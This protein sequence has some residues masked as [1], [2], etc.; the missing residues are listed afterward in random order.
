MNSCDWPPLLTAD[1]SDTQLSDDS[2]GTLFGRAATTWDLDNDGRSDTLVGAPARELS[3]AAS[4]GAVFL[5]SG[6]QAGDLTVADAVWSVRGDATDLELGYW[7]TAGWAP[8]DLSP[9]VFIA[10]RGAPSAY[11]FEGP[12][13]GDVS[14]A[15]AVGTLGYDH[16]SVSQVAALG[17][18]DGAGG[19]D[20]AGVSFLDAEEKGEED[21][22]IIR[23]FIAPFI[24]SFQREATATIRGGELL[25]GSNLVLGGQGDIGDDGLGDLVVGAP[26]YDPDGDLNAGAVFLFEDIGT[27][28]M[29]MEDADW[30]LTGEQPGDQA[31]FSSQV[32]GDIDGDGSRDLLVGSPFRGSELEGAVHI[33]TDEPASVGVSVEGTADFNGDGS[34]DLALGAPGAHGESASAGRRGAVFIFYGPLGEG[35]MS[36]ASCDVRFEGESDGRSLGYTVTS[37][38]VNSDGRADLLATGPAALAETP[39]ESP[40]GAYLLFGGGW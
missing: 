3:G 2:L 14:P 21:E 13:S 8:G 26:T 34:V 39:S 15:D 18:V 9:L 31:G 4:A 16:H 35:T 1:E 19:T 22:P 30:V 23:L 28:D 10:A 25:R 37:A 17:D 7:L 40:G 27:G 32:A 29:T 6:A 24:D 33:I 5:F 20:I 38:Q 12:F 36:T 11:V